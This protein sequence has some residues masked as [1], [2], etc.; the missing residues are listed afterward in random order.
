[1]M[2]RGGWS[3]LNLVIQKPVTQNAL[4]QIDMC[5][6]SVQI[7]IPNKLRSYSKVMFS[8]YWMVAILD[9]WAKMRSYD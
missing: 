5:F 1:M 2:H 6:E 7:T 4:I 9:F 8:C 3:H